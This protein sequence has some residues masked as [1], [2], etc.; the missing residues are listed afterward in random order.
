[1]R[2]I[3]GYRL[4]SKWK[5]DP[6]GAAS[7]TFVNPD[8]FFSDNT[9]WATA[10]VANDGIA[11]SPSRHTVV[12]TRASFATLFAADVAG[13]AGTEWARA[14]YLAR[15]VRTAVIFAGNHDPASVIAQVTPTHVSD[16]R[17][18]GV[19]LFFSS[20]TQPQKLLL[21]VPVDGGSLV[22]R[23]ALAADPVNQAL[24][25]FTPRYS[26]AETPI[27]PTLFRGGEFYVGILAD[28]VGVVPGGNSDFT[29]GSNRCEYFM[30]SS[31]SRS[32]GDVPYTPAATVTL[33]EGGDF[34]YSGGTQVLT[35]ELYRDGGQ[36]DDDVAALEA[37]A[38][39]FE[40][41]CFAVFSGNNPVAAT[42]A[43]GSTFALAA[44]DA[45][46]WGT[47]SVT[48]VDYR[49]VPCSLTLP[50]ADYAAVADEVV[51]DVLDF[52]S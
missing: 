3:S 51:T 52:F 48:G 14:G 43:V 23:T 17:A 11:T 49:V 44:T 38:A 36:I 5:A 1:M 46:T 24:A 16:L 27:D 18:A 8:G 33:V 10:G 32:A 40:A 15:R 12:H 31:R 7:G 50:A 20:Y 25:N 29:T 45:D 9:L 39:R 6:T 41:Y 47:V 26:V 21:G 19:D 30:T 22:Q 35:L 37:H 13:V 34:P 4:F 2:P 42:P 28:M